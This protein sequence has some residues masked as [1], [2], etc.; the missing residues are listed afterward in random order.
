MSFGIVIII[1]RVNE[2]INR[3]KKQTFSK[4][5][6]IRTETCYIRI[7]ILRLDI[8]TLYE[9]NNVFLSIR[10]KRI[11][12]NTHTVTF[13]LALKTYPITCRSGQFN[14]VDSFIPLRRN[15]TF[16]VILNGNFIL[17]KDYF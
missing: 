11:L 9:R 14:C 4:H 5:V 17:D 3:N 8:L 6:P 2:L 10:Q 7:K 13:R 12:W 15:F 16:S 1:L